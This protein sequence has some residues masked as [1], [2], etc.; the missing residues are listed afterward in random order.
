MDGLFFL[1]LLLSF[2][3][4]PPMGLLVRTS[5]HTEFHAGGPGRT[6]VVAIDGPYSEVMGGHAETGRHQSFEKLT[7][8][9]DG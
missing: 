7:R 2:A 9:L 4:Q 3:P 6:R 8:S 5:T 1:M